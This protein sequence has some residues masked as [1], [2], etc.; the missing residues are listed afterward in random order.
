[1]ILTVLTRRRQPIPLPSIITP[2]ALRLTIKPAVE[3]GRYDGKRKIAWRH[4][5]LEAMSELKLYG[6]RASFDEI[7]GKGNMQFAFDFAKKLAAIRSPLNFSVSFAEFTSKRIA[8]FRKY[9]KEM[10]ELST[11]Q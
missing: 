2:D 1:M 8:M 10:A 9:S 5:S 4:E 7:A 11:T 3:C 6:M